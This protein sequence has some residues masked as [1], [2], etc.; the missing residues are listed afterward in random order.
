MAK[1]ERSKLSAEAME[2]VTK[3]GAFLV[4]PGLPK[5]ERR[6]FKAERMYNRALA[7]P[8]NGT[9]GTLTVYGYQIKHREPIQLLTYCQCGEV[10][11]ATFDQLKKYE[12]CSCPACW[13]HEDAVEDRR[14][15]ND[16]MLSRYHALQVAIEYEQSQTLGCLVS[17]SEAK[18]IKREAKALY[19]KVGCRDEKRMLEER[20][21]ITEKEFEQY[22][23]ELFEDR[24]DEK[25][26]DGIK[27]DA[28]QLLNATRLYLSQY[29]TI[30]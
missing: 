30:I 11:K 26:R 3:D 17:S 14:K 10:V 12:V 22:V 19:K 2:R 27:Y 5:I 15:A 4:E 18:R 24:A 20:P 25:D 1:V 16:Y 21:P 6:V 13:D 8:Y 9:F 7:F 23:Y 29:Y 28:K